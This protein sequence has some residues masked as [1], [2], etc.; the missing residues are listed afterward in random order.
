[1]FVTVKTYNRVGSVKLL[2]Q[3]CILGF[4]SEE[5]GDVGVR[6]YPDRKEVLIS[7]AGFCGVS[8]QGTCAGETEMRQR[9]DRLWLG[10]NHAVGCG[11]IERSSLR[12]K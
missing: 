3:P 2:L 9:C 7:G 5:D 11:G 6:V 4:G 8:P 12:E 10:T 1:M